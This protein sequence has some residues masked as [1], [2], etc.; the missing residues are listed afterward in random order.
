MQAP[1]AASASRG[2]L[3]PEGK[4]GSC[5]AL[6]VSR[7]NP[8]QASGGWAG[9]A[10]LSGLGKPLPP[11]QLPVGADGSPRAASQE[12]CATLC[13]L[14][15]AGHKFT[16][17]APEVL[18]KV[19]CPFEH[20]HLLLPCPPPHTRRP[21]SRDCP[22]RSTLPHRGR[23]A[24]LPPGVVAQGKGKAKFRQ[25]TALNASTSHLAPGGGG[26]LAVPPSY[27]REQA[28]PAARG[29][30]KRPGFSPRQGCARLLHRA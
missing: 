9:R 2:T 11:P 6:Q 29:T 3:S 14:K 4:P 19:K 5:S 8:A 21:W 17:E 26:E 22:P 12:A 25:E 7:G 15:S 16:A 28:S 24:P 1:R 30:A 10:T 23:L 18:Q 20:A 13:L 27:L